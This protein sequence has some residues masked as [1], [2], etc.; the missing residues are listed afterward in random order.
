M[1]SAGSRE[2]QIFTNALDRNAIICMSACFAIAPARPRFGLKRRIEHRLR[3]RKLTM[4]TSKRNTWNW[5]DSVS[6]QLRAR[7]NSGAV[8][9]YVLVL[10]TSRQGHYQGNPARALQREL[11]RRIR[12]GEPLFEYFAPSYVEVRKQHGELVRTNHPLLYNY[13][14]IHASE[15]EIYRMKRFLPQFN[16]LPRIREEHNEHYPYLTDGAMANLRW[17]A[18][19]YSDVLPVYTPGPDRLMKGDRIR[20]T[21]G[22]FKGVEAT[23]VIQP[24]GGRKEV[25]V[26]VE[27][28][29]Y[30]PLLSVEPGQYEVVAL[31]SDG[32]H[33]Y[34]R[35]NGDRL[36]AGLHEALRRLHTTE[37]V[38]D[39]DRKLAT[40]VLQQYGSL[41]LES[42]VMR[43][44]LYALLLP[45]YAI[46]GDRERF[47]Q[48]L[49]TVRGILPLIR[50][51]QSRALLLVAL[52]GCTNCC[53]DY[54]QAHAVVD[55]WRTEQP[56]KKSKAQLIRRLD[57]YDRWLGHLPALA[58]S[59]G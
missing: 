19:S 50:A 54:A 41:Q 35:L 30:V 24:G 28:C 37:G 27:N 20:I 40:E 29:M 6:E 55:P 12:G 16:F 56:L 47:E 36:P 21:E 3:F 4:A 31:N 1:R 58:G 15:A 45:A 7:K 26:C 25:M 57:D 39:E 14:F 42:D 38:T 10:P 8:R 5:T 13:V 33:V 11:D 51:E 53:L 9:W 18:A 48:L 23:V 17:V 59:N 43:C 49:G 32:R 44:K 34:T 52:Y 22:Q 46:L 2:K